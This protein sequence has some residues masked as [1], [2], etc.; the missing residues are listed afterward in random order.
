MIQNRSSEQNEFIPFIIGV[1]SSPS[2][3]ER[4]VLSLTLFLTSDAIHD[5]EREGTA[6]KTFGVAW[7]V[8]PE[9]LQYM[10]YTSDKQKSGKKRVKT[11]PEKRVNVK[12]ERQWFTDTQTPY[13]YSTHAWCDS[14]SRKHVTPVFSYLFPVP[15][16]LSSG[17]KEND[18]VIK[19]TWPKLVQYMHSWQTR[20]MRSKNNESISS[21][22]ST[23]HNC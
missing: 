17:E 13:T 14:W 6:F 19:Q 8:M 1:I 15:G 10:Q 22:W 5:L 2:A 16:H 7:A 20:G 21:S 11:C 23:W 9:T 4:S 18:D 3:S 12:S